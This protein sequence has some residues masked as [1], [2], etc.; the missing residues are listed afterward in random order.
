MHSKEPGLQGLLARIGL[1]EAERLTIIHQDRLL[2]LRAVLSLR[3]I[4]D[5]GGPHGGHEDASLESAWVQHVL[6]ILTVFSARLEDSRSPK[7]KK[8]VDCL[9]EVTASRDS[10]GLG[11][12]GCAEPRAMAGHD[13]LR[14]PRLGDK[15]NR[16]DSTGLHPHR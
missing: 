14:P 1:G 3:T 11:A 16:A 7:P 6:K 15:A 9:Q 13:G 12:F 8:L 4:W 5:R 2:R 10:D